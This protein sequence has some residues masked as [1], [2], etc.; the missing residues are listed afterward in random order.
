MDLLQTAIEKLTPDR[1]ALIMLRYAEDFNIAQIAKILNILP[2]TVKSR[3]H[4]TVNELRHLMEPDQ[5]E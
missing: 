5:N 3:L 4:R 1:K 2:G